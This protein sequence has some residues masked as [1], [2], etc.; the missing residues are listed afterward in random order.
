MSLIRVE[1]QQIANLLRR[2]LPSEAGD[3]E[4][5]MA[6]LHVQVQIETE[7]SG[8]FFRADSAT[9]TITLGAE[10]ARRLQAHAFVVAI[11]QTVRFAPGYS[12]MNAQERA[13]KYSAADP[14]LTW[15]VARDLQQSLA[16]KGQKIN[17]DEIMEG[18]GAD[19][20]QDVLEGFSQQQWHV[21]QGLF[22]LA[23]LFIFLH[24]LAHLR[25]RHIACEGESAIEQEKQADRFAAE[26]LSKAT[27][28][29]PVRRLNCLIAV[30]VALI[31]LCVLNV[32]LGPSEG[33][34]HPQAYDRLFQTLNGFDLTE[35]TDEFLVWEFVA[36]S[37]FVHLDTAGIE[38]APQRMQGH[39]KDSANYLIDLISQRPS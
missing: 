10:F 34:R 18:G 39:P 8:I 28:S 23:I 30:A 21:G 3:I 7:D 33:R 16:R 9:N 27:A 24:E 38:V 36:Y 19:L 1:A 37:L 25:F 22:Q 32:F 11:F 26:C 17:L 35:A 13:S 29:D 14:L 31:W 2:W 4:R 15:A 6:D 5:V 12:T 20:P